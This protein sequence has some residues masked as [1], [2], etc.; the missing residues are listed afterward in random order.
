MKCG[1]IVFLKNVLDSNDISFLEKSDIDVSKIYV[2][3]DDFNELF[4]KLFR[5]SFENEDQAERIYDK[6]KDT[7]AYKNKDKAQTYYLNNIFNN[8]YKKI[9]EKYN[10]KLEDKEYNEKEYTDFLRATNK[11]SIEDMERIYDYLDDYFVEEEFISYFNKNV[12]IV[13]ENRK[14]LTGYVETIT[15]RADND[16][17]Q[18]SLTIATSNGYIEVFYNEV[19][20]I[21]EIK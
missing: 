11:M 18:A 9:L 6:I 5:I 13:L 10:I 20:S 1:E 3:K 7:T 8:D 19:K 15:R 14:E 17:N 12:H 2:T 21:N 4:D 16:N